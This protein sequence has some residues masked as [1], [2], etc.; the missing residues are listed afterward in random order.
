MTRLDFPVTI[1]A[2]LTWESQ[3]WQY[4]VSGPPGVSYFAG[5]VSDTHPG[6]P[7]VDSLLY[8]TEAGRLVGILNHYPVD[9][10]PWEKAGAIN[11]FIRRTHQRQGIATVLVAE[12]A[13][14]W[15]I[16]PSRQRYTASGAALARALT[17]R[18]TR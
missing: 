10:P 6:T 4:P 12:A 13:R 5:D 9:Y 1:G 14:R 3:V 16:D 11:V 18:K 15:D 17:E 8:R 7:P 2:T